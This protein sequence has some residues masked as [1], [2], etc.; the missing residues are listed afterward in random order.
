MKKYKDLMNYVFDQLQR[1]STNDNHLT[2][3]SVWFQTIIYWLQIKISLT[4]IKKTY[5]YMHLVSEQTV[6]LHKKTS[7]S[8]FIC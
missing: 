3:I 2:W 5:I 8:T 7:S 4:T 6:F 1:Q